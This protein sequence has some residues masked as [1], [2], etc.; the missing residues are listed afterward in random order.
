MEP[1][2]TQIS[3]ELSSILKELPTFEKRGITELSVHDKKISG[4]KNALLNLCRQIQK[5]APSL[6]VSLKTEV[7]ALD[8]NIIGELE[9]IYCSLEIPLVGTE[10]GDALLL[11]KKL[12][13]SKAD[14]LNRSNIVFGFDLEYGM[15]KGD[16]FKSFKDRLDFA[17]SLYPNHIDFSQLEDSTVKA[18]PSGIYSSKDIDFSASIAFA[19]KTFYSAGRAVPWF[20]SLVKALKISPSAFFADF[21]EWQICNNC[22]KKTGF[23][24]DEADHADIEKMQLVFIK[25]KLEEK[26]RMMLYDA[27]SDIVR[28]NGAF[29][30]VAA[31]GEE[32]TVETSYNPDDLLSPFASD[33]PAF[34]DGVT[35][36]PCKVRVF[37]GEDSPDYRILT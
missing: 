21:G 25:E 28:L 23:S 10:K 18:K 29:S 8:R 32:S 27:V 13:S 5:D 24:P 14:M 11:D 9:K 3:M 17:V 26:R 20:N 4:D 33:I 35:M 34:C 12:Y 37:E 7:S 31:E 30:R 2:P 36:E 1:N 22:S 19:C 16:S 15:K 6:F